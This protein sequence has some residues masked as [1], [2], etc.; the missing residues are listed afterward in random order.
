[1]CFYV[2]PAIAQRHAVMPNWR[3]GSYYFLA[4]VAT[5]LMA[6]LLWPW[7]SI[8]L[9]PATACLVAAAAYFGLGP[10]IYRKIDG[11]LTLST[12]LLLAPLFLGQKLSLRYYQ[13]QCNAWDEVTPQVWIGRKLT[14]REAADA[15]RKGVTAVL[16]VT[17]E[18]SEAAP[19]S[20][21]PLPERPHPGS[22]GPNARA[23]PAVRR[24]HI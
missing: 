13:R 3:V 1:M 4:S 14:D 12:R 5:S 18:F 11:R 17:A 6:A 23:N 19:V 7:G 15:V 9:W 22:H 20:I 2:V 16:D 8:F 24:F 10:G 21:D